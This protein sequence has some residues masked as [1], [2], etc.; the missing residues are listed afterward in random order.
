MTPSELAEIALD[1]SFNHDCDP[2]DEEA[3]ARQRFARKARLW[4][5][6]RVAG[7]ENERHRG[8]ERAIGHSARELI[9]W[10]VPQGLRAT[11]ELNDYGDPTVRLERSG[12]SPEATR[13]MHD[14][15]HQG[16]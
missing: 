9:R 8:I 15:Q 11:I 10:M 1:A 5:E 6:I 7:D 3:H 16:N 2:R 13:H 12:E 14:E 4:A